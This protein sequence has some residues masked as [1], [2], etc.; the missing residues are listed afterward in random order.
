ML[1]EII[2]RRFRAALAEAVVLLSVLPVAAQAAPF[3]I[4]ALPDTEYYTQTYPWIFTAQTQWIVDHKAAENIAFVTHMGD[5]VHH[6]GTTPAQWDVVTG[7]MYKLDGVLPWSPGYGN[8]ESEDTPGFVSRFG[9]THFAGDIW[10][11]GATTN[12]LNSC[13]VFSAGGYDFLHIT[14]QMGFT[15]SS[16]NWV[17]A[18]IQENP[19]KPTI[20]STHDY[21]AEGGGG[22]RDPAGDTLWNNLIKA[23]PQVFMVLCGHNRIP[24]RRIDTNS[25]GRM[26]PQMMGNYQS[27][28]TDGT[29]TD[30]GYLR[31]IIFDPDN[32]K[33]SIQTYSPTFAAQ[34]WLTSDADQFSFDAAFLPQVAG[35]TR[36][37]V[38]I[39][40]AAVCRA[41]GGFRQD[42][43]TT[44]GPTGTAMPVGWTAWQIA[45]TA[46]TFSNAHKM[47]AADIAASASATQTLVVADA[48][49]AGTW[50]PQ[51]ANAGAGPG[52]RALASNPGNNAAAVAQLKITN[53]TGQPVTSVRLLYDLA[54]PW[55]SPN[56][57]GTELPGY[58]LFW[59][60]TGSTAAGD[61][62]RLGE[63]AAAG[64]KAWEFA[65]PTA[66]APG[67]DI[68]LR[69]AD[70]NA[71]TP[72]GEAAAEN[73][74]A[75]DNIRVDMNVPL[76]PSRWGDAN[77]DGK[78]DPFD[79]LIVKDR[80][81]TVGTANWQDGDFDRDGDV[82]RDDLALLGANF[83]WDSSVP[84]PPAD[85]AAVPEPGTIFLLA[86]GAMAL[87]RAR[88][89]GR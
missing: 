38:F 24:S 30:T 25:I 61:W 76:S 56:D 62:A 48:A 44:P 78:V 10:Y 68:Y 52:G 79:Y 58:S 13:Q 84:V 42:F 83:G 2:P 72:A 73:V 7:A 9:P 37:P 1:S 26:V 45:G 39:T 46:G 35:S 43:Q 82:D 53:G 23:N 27:Y 89:R 14:L 51:L 87:T 47:A 34:P 85:A 74:W 71:Q 22:G 57:A 50:G 20:I 88:K 40:D 55:A 80:M 29:N 17:L 41:A 59:S 12:G 11:K 67:A 49:P 63:D 5:M 54:M 21:M 18:R 65:L 32:G 3:E 16:V 6:P 31:K 81:G 36:S 19:G 70:D 86:A 64:L 77:C 69:W 4:I 66:L 75:I 33:I 8:H 28:T 15:T 60:A